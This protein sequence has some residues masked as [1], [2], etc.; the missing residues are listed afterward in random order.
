V[1]LLHA[2]LASQR[3]D[4]M[5]LRTLNQQLLNTYDLT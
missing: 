1:E 5:V 3:Q 2:A 4:G